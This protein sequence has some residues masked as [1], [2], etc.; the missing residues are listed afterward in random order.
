M[1]GIRTI[2]IGLD[3][4]LLTGEE[5]RRA[6]KLA[7]VIH[8]SDTLSAAATT[9]RGDLPRRQGLVAIGILRSQHRACGRR[10]EG[11]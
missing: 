5:L 1:F 4:L 6:E 2:I 8:A 3:L 11:R 7:V 10:L 9:V